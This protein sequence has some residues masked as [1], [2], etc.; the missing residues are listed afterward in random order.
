MADKRS[1]DDVFQYELRKRSSPEGIALAALGGDRKAIK[2]FAGLAMVAIDSPN[3]EFRAGVLP[4]LIDVLS[5][6]HSGAEPNEAFG[7]KRK[8]AGAP[9]PSQDM[10]L[11]L[12]HI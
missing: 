7:W 3:A 10:D 9:S 11:S 4:W 8:R 12:I 6:I 2:D 1:L 5:Q